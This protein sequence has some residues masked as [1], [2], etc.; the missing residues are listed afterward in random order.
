MKKTLRDSLKWSIGVTLAM[1]W[2]LAQA[3]NFTVSPI[4][5]DL[6]QA[7]PSVALTVKNEVAD[8]PLI[9]QLRTVAWSQDNGVDVHGPT[10]EVLATP[11]IFTV[12]P[13]GSQV[14]RIGL[15]R[16]PG[17]EREASY[18]LYLREVPPAPKPDFAGV[19]I[20]LEMSLPVFAN[21]NAPTTPE[22]RWKAETEEN[23]RIKLSVKND[24]NAH[25]KVS[26]LIVSASDS[27]RPVAALPGFAY[28]LPG[29]TR[30]LLLEP[31]PGQMVIK[32]SALRLKANT[33]AGEIDLPLSA[34]SQ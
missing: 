14:V 15:R 20:A 11:P 34:Q 1:G 6:S 24:G 22:L 16:P 10:T 9:V 21:P 30:N 3:A 2:V 31:A 7:R 29:Q 4:R 8:E 18:R 27:N 5:V 12:P 33:D 32:G 26:N 19:Q 23:G 13:G 17:P 28:I 25:A